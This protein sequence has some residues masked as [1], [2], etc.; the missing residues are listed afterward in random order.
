MLLGVNLIPGTGEFGYDTLPMQGAQAGAAFQTLNLNAAP[1]GTRTDCSIALDQLQ[2]AYP[3]VTTVA[4][5]VSWFGNSI[6][7]SICKLYPSTNFIDGE[8]KRLDG[9]SDDWRCS[10][11]TQSSASLIPISTSGGGATYGGTPSDSSVF[12]CLQDLKARGLRTIFYPFILMD[13]PGLPWRGRITYS[14]DLSST[15]T[16]A[17]EAFFGAATPSQFTRDATNLTVAYSGLA[18]DWTFRRMILHYANLVVLA[19]GVDLFLLGSELRG[20]ETIRGPG[21]TKAGTTGGDGKVVWD[22]PFVDGLAALADDVRAIFDAASLTKDLSGLHNLIA[23]SADWSDWMGFQHAG[24]NGQWPHLDQL[25][26]HDNIDI[27]AFDNYLPLSD[28]TSGAG[29]LDAINWSAPKPSSWP[30]DATAMNGLGLSGPPTILSKDY[31]KANIEGGEKFHWFYAD[32]DNLGR[33][34]DP[35]GTS[36]QVS[37]PAGDRLAQ[38]RSPYFAGQEILANKQIRW[39]WNAI[40]QAVY[41]NGDGTGWS[42]HGPA[43]K[44][45]AQS[46]PIT[47]VE[48]GFPTIDRA[49]NQPNVF[50]DPRSSE[51]FTPYWSTWDVVA[52]GGFEPTRDETLAVLAREAIEEYWTSDGHNEIAA[53]VPMIQTAFMAAWNW[54]ARPFPAFPLRSDLWGDAAGWPFGSWI[55][56]KGP[57]LPPPAEP[58]PPAPG[59]YP[60]FPQLSGRGWSLHQRPIFATGEAEFVSGRSRRSAKMAAPLW[61]FELSYD[62]LRGKPTGDLAAIVGFFNSLQGMAAPFWF[63]PS[64]LSPLKGQSLGIG[65]GTRNVFPFQRS[66]GAYVEPLASVFNATNIYESGVALSPAAYTIDAA[67]FPAAVS[68]TTAPTTGAEIS[69]DFSYYLLCRFAEDFEDAEEFMDALYRLQVLKLRS[70]K[71]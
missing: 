68:F 17:V 12:R 47:F 35:A 53:G 40:H 32:G 52:G 41:D 24:A 34:F 2:S 9:S 15:A 18:T 57:S 20:L 25:W 60:V 71:L 55:G 3:S 61:E 7:A 11:L 36:L 31:L 66:I 58:M 54:D 14:P 29:G 45:V 42:P 43:T 30:P 23:Y 64:G 48:Y 8:F 65:D 16:A 63:E 5:V 27:V 62:L 67:G 33:G 49:T 44:W 56:G 6:D 69:A 39:W 50:Y 26:G 28:W 19:G 21:W 22:Y 51:S 59:I 46:K 13:A 37:L 38:N 1:S 4:L 70:V 10:S